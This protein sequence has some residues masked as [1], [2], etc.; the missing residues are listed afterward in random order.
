MTGLRWSEDQ[1]MRSRA[2]NACGQKRAGS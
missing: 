1:I 2:A